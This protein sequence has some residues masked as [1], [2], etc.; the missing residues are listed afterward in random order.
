[1][2]TTALLQSQY[3]ALVF[4][5]PQRRMARTSGMSHQ[6]L[7]LL[8]L[9]STLLIPPH[10]PYFFFL[11]TRQ[12]Q[13]GRL[14]HHLD[15]PIKRKV[16]SL[17]RVWGSWRLTQLGFALRTECGDRKGCW[18]LTLGKNTCISK[19]KLLETYFVSALFFVN[20]LFCL[21]L[22]SVDCKQPFLRFVHLLCAEFCSRTIRKAQQYNSPNV[23]LTNLIKIPEYITCSV[24]YF[25]TYLS[26]R[27]VC[28]KN[29]ELKLVLYFKSWALF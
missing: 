22:V 19:S 24:A 17:S 27:N 14:I 5:V 15:T 28:H 3:R 6:L 26:D 23:L 7:V 2:N 10:T 8:I 29:V 12:N 1:M 11:L 4:V 9:Q 18:P 20:I 16:N 25:V 21:L 13:G